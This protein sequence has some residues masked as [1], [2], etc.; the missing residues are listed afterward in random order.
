M[1]QQR[2][3]RLNPKD[4]QVVVPD[5]H[6]ASWKPIQKLRQVEGQFSAIA[7]LQLPARGVLEHL[8]PKATL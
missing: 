3:A 5:D 1:G 2:E 4:V 6:V 8:V 7:P